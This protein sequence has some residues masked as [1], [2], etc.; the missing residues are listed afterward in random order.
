LISEAARKRVL[1]FFVT[2]I[3]ATAI[4]EIDRRFNTGGIDEGCRCCFS[5]STSNG[6]LLPLFLFLLNE[7]KSS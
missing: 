1:H 5:F 4:D 6:L 3:A 7:E 2:C